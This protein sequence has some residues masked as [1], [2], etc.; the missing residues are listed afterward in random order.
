LAKTAK[1]YFLQENK[2]N[3][4]KQKGKNIQQKGW[5]HYLGSDTVV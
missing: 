1:K 2:W 4:T 5:R 3:N